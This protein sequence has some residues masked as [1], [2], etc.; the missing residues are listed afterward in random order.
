MPARSRI[1]ALG[2]VTHDVRRFVLEKP[3]GFDFT[4]GQATEVMLDLDGWREEGR[5]FTFT[6]LPENPN[7]EL[8][9]KTYPDHDGV[10]KRLHERSIGDTL[11]LEDVF[12]AI[13]YRGPGVFLAGGAGITPFI[14]IFRWLEKTDQVAGNRLLF[15]NKSEAD[16]IDREM[17]VRMLGDDAVFT[18]T[19]EQHDRYAHGRIDRSFIERHVADPGDQRYYLCGPPAMVDQLSEILEQMGATSDSVVIEE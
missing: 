18:L 5:P 11:L 9:I 3:D 14:A 12:G 13:T 6:S 7:L 10:T 1:L 17:F 2:E 8:T 15:A 4:P 16:I 19:R